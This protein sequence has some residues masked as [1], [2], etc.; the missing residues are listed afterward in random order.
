MSLN[1]RH[2]DIAELLNLSRATVS[3][4]LKNPDHPRFSEETRRRVLQAAE[5]MDYRPNY[6][7]RA[8]AGG[9]TRTIG[10]LANGMQAP[11]AIEKVRSIETA[12]AAAEYLA[13]MV[14]P[15]SNDSEDQRRAIRILV[16]RRVD[17][18]IVFGS[19]AP[20]ASAIEALDALSIPVVYMDWAPE[21]AQ[22]AV[23]VRREPGIRQAAEHLA[24][25]GHEHVALMLSPTDAADTW[26]R[27]QPFQ[28]AFDRLGVSLET[29]PAWTLDHE[30]GFYDHAYRILRERLQHRTFPTAI[31]MNN[32]VCAIAAMAAVADAGLCIPGDVSL[33]GFDDLPLSCFLR[34][35]LTTVH[36][37]RGEV[38][39]A[40][41]AMLC[42]LM[43]SPGTAMQ[44]VVFD[45]HLVVRD[46]TRPPRA[47]ISGFV[48]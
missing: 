17:G 20:P 18:V 16:E 30:I 31:V 32:D 37:P 40:A 29:G 38:G 26:R 14:S 45:C 9:E 1:I 47:G 34:P 48:G 41:F 27:L 46:S 19:G 28:Q 42:S 10:I 11:A 3:K 6:L 12:A 36:Q 39:Q 7:G 21:G 25:L 13:F 35:A 2:S 5:R 23:R 8:L 15:L 24:E 33:I 43:Q 44:P 22:S 4:V